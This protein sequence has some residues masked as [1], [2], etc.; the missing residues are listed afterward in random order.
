MKLFERILIIFFIFLW[1]SSYGQIITSPEFPVANQEV[2]IIFDSG[3]ESR[4]EYFTGDLYAHTGVGIEG[5]GNWQYV[6]ESWNNNNTQPKLTNKGGGIYELKITPDIKS[7][8]KVPDNENIINMTFVFRSSDGSKQTNDLLVTVY[9]SGL[10]VDLQSPLTNSIY[11]T[12]STVEFSALASSSSTITLYLDNILMETTEG[13]SLTYRKQFIEPG[14]HKVLVIAQST[15]GITVKDSALFCVMSSTVIEPLP[16]G[17]KKG[18]NYI[19][20][21]TVALCLLA[22]NK[23]NV[24]V[25]G[26]FN[27]WMPMNKYQMKKD[28]DNFWIMLS[29]LDKGKEYGLQYLIDGILLIADPYSDK[30]SDPWNDSKISNTTYPDLYIY[31]SGKTEGITTVIETGKK[32]YAWQIDDFQIPDREKIV[33]YEMLIRDFTSEHTY[34][35]I[36]DKLD[37]LE[38]LQINVLELMPVNEFEGNNSWGYN[39]SFYLA[40]DKFYGQ[41]DELKMLIDECHKRGIA[42]V[43]D[44]VLNHSYG[45]NPLV[46]MY[47]DKANSRPSSE[48]PWYNTVSPNQTYSWGYDFNHLSEATKEFVDSVNSY[49]LN[50]FNVDGF[51]FDFTKGFTNTSGD[52]W[53]Y[54][55]SRITILK[56]MADEIWKRKPGALV[57]CEHLADNIEEKELANHGLMLWGNMNWNYGEAAMGYFQ[58]NNSDIS[59]GVYTKR[60]WNKPNLV[61]Y[62]ESHDEERITY[63][64]LQW[65]N[66]IS[67][68]NTKEIDTAI[69]RMKINAVFHLPLPGPKMIWQFGEL[70]Y[71]YSINTCVNGTVNDSCRLSM[72]PLRWDYTEIEKRSELFRVYADLNYLKKNYEEFSSNDFKVS[73]TGPQKV[74]YF[75]NEDNH[76]VIAGNFSFETST[77]KLDFPKTGMWYNYFENSQITID[78]TTFDIELGP[79]EYVILSTREFQHT[80]I[81]TVA[82][83]EFSDNK[84]QLFYPNPAESSIYFKT[85]DSGNVYIYSTDSRLLKR[86]HTYSNEPIDIS[87]L[88]K[89]IYFIRRI[90]KNGIIHTGKLIK[91]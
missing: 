66:S 86:I 57:I 84:T 91:N 23:D 19:D 15:E 76:V 85:D 64:C 74:Y 12:N 80:E 65:G 55:A 33:I 16:E 26:D 83:T 35:S 24:F 52:G 71:D 8:Y 34:K 51:R 68:Y 72:K 3:K 90:S 49:W 29:G 48:N 30:I 53:A 14:D 87:F 59:N 5:K 58:G 79:G 21:N 11:P 42:V 44:M 78:N 25:L 70:G 39:P 50:E 9:S 77:I 62:Q 36:I 31:P 67:G 89:G 27:N 75:N 1:Q 56:R 17:I 69:D 22:P 10:N 46:K 82:K 54:D 47:W 40:P 6:I 2:T 28:G 41:K 13:L 60:G 73:L 81:N 32:K 38:D 63:K 45:Q 4:L 18:I 20:D 37:Y 7:F 43:I 61:T 88:K